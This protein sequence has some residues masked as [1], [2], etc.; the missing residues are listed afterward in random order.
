MIACLVTL[1]QV[2]AAELLWGVSICPRLQ[3]KA[4]YLIGLYALY[5][6]AKS[7]LISAV[8]RVIVS[9]VVGVLLVHSLP[10]HALKLV[11]RDIP[12]P[13]LIPTSSLS[14]PP[15]HSFLLDGLDYLHVGRDRTNRGNRRDLE[16]FTCPLVFIPFQCVGQSILYGYTVVPGACD[17]MSHVL[18]LFP[19]ICLVS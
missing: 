13:Y 12:F 11:N 3:I 6:W 2:S 8:D 17:R 15:A 16:G 5:V 18:I 14:Y 19:F 7:V 1:G 4:R 10:I 9:P